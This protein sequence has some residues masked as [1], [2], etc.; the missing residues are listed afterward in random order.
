MCAGLQEAYDDTKCLT[1]RSDTEPLQMQDCTYE[2]SGS[3]LF[4]FVW[5]DTVHG[6][7]PTY[8]IRAKASGL[9][10][11]LDSGSS[12]AGIQLWECGALPSQE[13]HFAEGV[14]VID[15]A[16]IVWG[17]ACIPEGGVDV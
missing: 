7:R 11:D 6:G 9:C 10:L 1:A 17:H 3:Q 5:R 8:S 16:G 14:E 15:E 4:S 2:A 12:L 13:F